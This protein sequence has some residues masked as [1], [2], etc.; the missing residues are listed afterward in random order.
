M[1]SF[2]ARGYRTIAVD[3]PP[4][5]FSEKPVD[6]SYGNA[7]QAT[8]IVSLL[9]QLGVERVTL[10]GH[11]FGG[12][13]TLE[14]A[15]RIPTRVQS[16]ILEDIGGLHLDAPSTGATS[17]RGVSEGSTEEAGVSDG[18]IAE[19]LLRTPTFRDPL[20]ALTATNPLLTRRL[21]QSMVFDPNVVTDEHVAILRRPLTLRGGTHAFGDWLHEAL[22]PVHRSSTCDRLNYAK[23]SMPALIVWGEQDTIIPLS[24]G[25]ELASLL[26]N[27]HLEVL[28]NVNHIP[29]I[30]NFAAVTALAS[31]FLESNIEREDRTR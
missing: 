3:L 17:E 16:L 26:P 25:E 12:G 28:P 19:W 27:A 6:G 9:D 20:L 2:S 24:A 30:E 23:L 15:L 18:G 14:T 8:R 10:F 22:F 7:A 21:L 4:F 1:K 5:G 11:S 13:A 31:K 29:H